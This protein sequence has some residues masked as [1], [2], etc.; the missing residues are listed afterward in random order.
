MHNIILQRFNKVTISC[1]THRAF[2]SCNHCFVIHLF[3]S[4]P[5]TYLSIQTVIFSNLG[6][7]SF[8]LNRTWLSIKTNFVYGW[9][10]YLPNNFELGKLL[11]VHLQEIKLLIA[12]RNYFKINITDF[13]SWPIFV[14]FF[15]LFQIVCP[16]S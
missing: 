11:N 12:V 7:N 16:G 3:A 4:L 5:T 8:G 9:L 13:W 10:H 6:H 14:D 15:S 2:F 1:R